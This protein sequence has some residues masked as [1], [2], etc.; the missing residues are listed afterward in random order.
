MNPLIIKLN[1]EIAIT[2][3]QNATSTIVSPIVISL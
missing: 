1:E 2:R 3:I